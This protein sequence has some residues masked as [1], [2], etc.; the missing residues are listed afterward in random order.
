MV[1]NNVEIQSD[2]SA[3]LKSYLVSKIENNY[4]IYQSNI[5][6]QQIYNNQMYNNFKNKDN[7]KMLI[8]IFS[9]LILIAIVL[10]IYFITKTKPEEPVDETIYETAYRNLNFNEDLSLTK[11]YCS[12]DISNGTEVSNKKTVIYYFDKNVLKTY[13]Y[14]NE[15]V[16][17]NAYMD[18][19]DEM[20]NKYLESLKKDYNYRNVKKSIEKGDNEILVT[21]I[22]SDSDSDDSLKMPNFVSASEAKQ[23]AIKQGYE[24]K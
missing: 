4:F 2:F 22:T 19:Y 15:I 17:S 6:N 20:Y 8:I 18:Y 14:H 3:I 1:K 13:I 10:C 21:I 23:K 12:L 16:L 9:I 7:K 11:V 24:C 5:P